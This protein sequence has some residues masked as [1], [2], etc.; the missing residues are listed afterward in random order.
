MR[1]LALDP[2][3]TVGWAAFDKG[4]SGERYHSGQVKDDQVWHLLESSKLNLKGLDLLIVES[5]KYRQ[6]PKADLTPVEVIGIV[7]EWA[8]QFQVDVTWQTP[9]QAKFFFT[10]DRIKKLGL[11]QPGKPHAM[12]AMRHLLYYLGFGK[13]VVLGEEVIVR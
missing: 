11:Y 10:D 7:K 1:L 2:G 8:R 12:D 6:L 13:G 4:A 3:R 5:F 9:S